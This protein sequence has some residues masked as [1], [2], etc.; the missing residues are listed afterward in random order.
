MIRSP[1]DLDRLMKEAGQVPG[2]G[3]YGAPMK[4]GPTPHSI[5]FAQGNSLSDID[6]KTRDAAQKPG[7]G[8]YSRTGVPDLHRLPQ[9]D[10]EW[11]A[12]VAYYPEMRYRET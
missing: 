6:I 11:K 7:P 10:K 9:T 5:K 4:P 8:Q 12:Y 2:P 1:S 3:R